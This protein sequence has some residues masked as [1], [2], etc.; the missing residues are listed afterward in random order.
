MSAKLNSNTLI[1]RNQSNY[2]TKLFDN[3][4]CLNKAYDKN[5]MQILDILL[6]SIANE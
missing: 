2:N 6:K 5:E 3:G 1:H 4:W